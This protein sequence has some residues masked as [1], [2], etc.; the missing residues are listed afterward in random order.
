MPRR[1]VPENQE[2]IYRFDGQ[3]KDGW[4]V[5][6]E[7]SGA[8]EYWFI[9]D[10]KLTNKTGQTRGYSALRLD[11]PPL[12]NFVFKARLTV[13]ADGFHL[14]FRAPPLYLENRKGVEFLLRRDGTSG[15]F[16]YPSYLNDASTASA[17][18]GTFELEVI[19][20]EDCFEAKL[21][22]KT[23]N[24][25]RTRISTP[26]QGS[27]WISSQGGKNKVLI[28]E[29]QVTRLPDDFKRLEPA[30]A[31]NN[32]QFVWKYAGGQFVRQ[33]QQLVDRHE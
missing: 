1:E 6:G 2:I 15:V 4:A 5:P 24:F 17:P 29:L 10:G 9:E 27:L 28:E 30:E 16:H 12:K 7:I 33:T 13:V 22:G 25:H 32:G 26:Q 18:E 3:T 31:P 23:I 20:A 19:A 8:E 14:F 21:N 11:Q